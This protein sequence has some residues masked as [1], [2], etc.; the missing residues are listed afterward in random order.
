MHILFRESHGLEETATPQDL[1]QT[2]A[3]LVVL[4]YAPVTPITL[5]NL[6]GHLIFGAKCG[7]AWMTLVDGNIL[8]SQGEFP[9]LD[10]PEIRSEARKAAEF[11][12]R[13]FYG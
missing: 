2:P 13:R 6:M 1:G 4:D 11:L 8:Y 7:R 10:E 5:D 9:Y 3:D 12:R